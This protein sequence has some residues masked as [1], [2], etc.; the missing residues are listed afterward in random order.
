[1]SAPSPPL[2][3][4]TLNAMDRDG[5]VA[6]LGP[7]FENA[8]WVAAEAWSERPFAS[9]AALHAAMLDVVRRAPV[10][11]VEIGPVCEKAARLREIPVDRSNGQRAL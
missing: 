3:L 1:M 9:V 4:T 11:M 5:F 2:D 7:A 6:V 10:D 8:P